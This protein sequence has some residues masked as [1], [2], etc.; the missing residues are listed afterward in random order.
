M[1]RTTSLLQ[2]SPEKILDIGDKWDKKRY[3]ENSSR[4]L[5]T[6]SRIYV[7]ASNVSRQPDEGCM[8]KIKIERSLKLRKEDFR[9]KTFNP[10]T[11]TGCDESNWINSFAGQKEQLYEK[12]QP[13]V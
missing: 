8:K 12:V 9:S 1:K 7:P 11:N 2:K 3:V 10:V 5:D 13:K 4:K 6:Y